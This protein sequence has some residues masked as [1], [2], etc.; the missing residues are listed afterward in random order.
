MPSGIRRLLIQEMETLEGASRE[1]RPL[2]A[3]QRRRRWPL[4]QGA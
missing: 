1:P 3:L 4:I 2:M